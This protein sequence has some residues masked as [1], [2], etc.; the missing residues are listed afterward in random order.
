M[1][2]ANFAWEGKNSLTFSPDSS[3][4]NHI[5]DRDKKSDENKKN[6]VTTFKK[7]REKKIKKSHG[8][9][10]EFFSAKQSR[11]SF[12]QNIRP[13][14]SGENNILDFSKFFKII[15]FVFF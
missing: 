9:W 12:L 6:R 7:L 1:N 15:F 3:I 14:H 8:I 11:K 5:F 10:R 4:K 2:T 13:T